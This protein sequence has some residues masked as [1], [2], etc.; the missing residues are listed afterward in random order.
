MAILS[1]PTTILINRENST[2]IV[3]GN[4]CSECYEN[5]CIP[6]RT[7]AWLS[8][9]QAVAFY[10]KLACEGCTFLCC[11]CFPG[12][13]ARN[14]LHPVGLRGEARRKFAR[15]KRKYDRSP[16]RRIVEAS[17]RETHVKCCRANPTCGGDY[18]FIM[19]DELNENWVPEVNRHVQQYGYAVHAVAWSEEYRQ[20]GGATTDMR[21]LGIFVDA[22]R[23]EPAYKTSP[24]LE[25]AKATE[26]R[27]ITTS[28]F[29][30]VV[31]HSISS[32]DE[33]SCRSEHGS[34][35][36]WMTSSHLQQATTDETK[37]I[38]LTSHES[39]L[40]NELSSKVGVFAK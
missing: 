27:S 18:L 32:A 15:E 11:C 9:P 2:R 5:I 40:T 7:Q 14:D 22:T 29:P 28:G 21:F 26:L 19:K 33:F 13:F 4:Q 1:Y 31:V 24:P 17:L 34:V 30:N 3:M 38:C 39:K 6:N 25:E 23:A 37:I 36:T 8:H 12:G 16:A 20:E 10:E 35:E